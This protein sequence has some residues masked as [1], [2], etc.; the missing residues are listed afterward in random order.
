M[1]QALLMPILAIAGAGMSALS[2]ISA[3]RQ[4]N[5]AA[6]YEARQMEYNAK[7][8]EA[9]GQQEAIKARREAN[10]LASRAL[11]VAGASGAGTVDPNVLNIV[12]GIQGEGEYNA[13]MARYNTRSQAESMR[14]QAGARRLE[15]KNAA[16]AG[17]IDAG[18]TIL[19]GAAVAGDMH[20]GMTR[21]NA[22]RGGFSGLFGKG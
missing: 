6:K 15:G 19:S 7:Q 16:K 2:S 5:A 14:A 4:Q 12:S 22:T 20:F 1:A 11:A 13:Q 9:A 3:G 10:L 8:Q 21:P 18:S 17:W